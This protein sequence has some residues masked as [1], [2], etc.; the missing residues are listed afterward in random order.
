MTTGKGG[1]TYIITTKKNTVLYTGVTSDLKTRI[2]EHKTKAYPKSFTA[3]YNADKLIWHEFHQRIES[4]IDREK[5]IKG[6]LRKKKVIQ[7][8]FTNPEWKDLY[9]ELD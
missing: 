9:H 8:E 7:I 1:W 5:Q 2:Y 4:A 3:R 6:W